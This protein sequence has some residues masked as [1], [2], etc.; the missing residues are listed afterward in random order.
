VIEDVHYLPLS[1]G[2]GLISYKLTESG[3]S[4][5]HQFSAKAY[6]SSIWEKR[7]GGWTC[8]FSQ[9]TAMPR[10]VAATVAAPK[11]P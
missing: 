6:I 3:V 7:A 1:E 9:E 2:S 4:H 11:T 5:G 8:L 10:P